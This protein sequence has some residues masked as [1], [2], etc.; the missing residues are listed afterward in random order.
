MLQLEGSLDLPEADAYRDDQSDTRFYILPKVPTIRQS[1][2]KLAFQYVKYRTLKPLANGDVG[3]ALVFMDIA[4][5]LSKQQEDDI[6]TRLVAAVKARRGPNDSRPLGP[7]HIEFA[8]IPI[9]KAAVSVEIL[10]DS[11][12]L[13]QKVNHAGTPSAYG[14]NVVAVSAEL[15][16]LGAPIFEAA[17]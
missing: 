16:Q 11:G 6:R 10:A 5:A 12:N 7:E 14:S 8:K 9:T 3:A 13:V 15:N 17:M 2:G 1:A 4:L